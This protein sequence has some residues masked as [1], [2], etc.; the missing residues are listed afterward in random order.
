[1]KI[2]QHFLNFIF[3]FLLI[4]QTE[5]PGQDGTHR[6]RLPVASKIKDA[7]NIFIVKIRS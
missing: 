6:C 5:K 3:H 2:H 7:L 4:L 1:M